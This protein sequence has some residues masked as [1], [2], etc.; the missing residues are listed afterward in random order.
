MGERLNCLLKQWDRVWSRILSN[1][2]CQ[3][4]N[5]RAFAR[6]SGNAAAQ[7]EHLEQR[8][9][10]S[11]TSALSNL[12]AE[13]TY[14]LDHHASPAASAPSGPTGY[15]PN[16]IR[17]AY[18]FSGT[19]NNGTGQTIAIVDAYDDPTIQNDLR[20]F[21]S[22]FGLANP[23]TMSVISQTGSATGLPQTD[24]TK[25]WE[26]EESL[27]VEWAHALAPAANI[28]L[29]EANSASYAD[30]LAAVSTAAHL[31]NVSVVSMSWGGSEFSGES[32][33][34]S[35][36]TTP[37]GHQGVTF[38][39]STGD[40]GAPGGFPAFSRNVV[41]VGG[42][43]LNVNSSG[44]YSSESGWSGSGGGIS[45]QE[46]QP[47][48]Q[49]GIVTQTTTKRAIP[50]V[51]FDADPNSGV[52]VYDSF[53]LGTTNPW[54][55]VGGTSFS[56]PAWGAIVSLA[57]QGRALHGLSSLDGASQA[58]PMLYQLDHT[59]P[60][61]FHDVTSGSNG[62]AAGTGYD[63]V[64]GL[65]TPVVNNLISGL[66]GTTTSSTSKLVFTQTPT[67]GTAGQTLGTL[68]VAIENLSGQVVTSDN[69]AVTLSI[70]SGPGGFTGASTVT[71]N[72]V[73]GIATFSNLV[74]NVSGAY[75][76]N[77]S[78]GT[79]TNGASG[80]VTINAAQA[81]KVAFQQ[82]PTAGV[83]GHALSTV[84]AAVEDQF[85]NVVATNN[86]NVTI[87]VASGGGSFASGS[88][89]T[90]SAVN[91][92]ATFNNLVLS[93]A[94]TYTLSATD[95]NLTRA[96][97][98][99]ISVTASLTAPQNF[100]VTALNSTTAQLSWSSVSGTQG[101][102]VFQVIGTQ[103]ILLGSLSSSATSAQVSG[104]LSGSTDSFKIEAYS[105]T[106]VADSRVV[107]VTMPTV[108]LTTPVLSISAI[109]STSVQLNWTVSEGTQGYR[110]Y[111]MNGTTKTLI[112]TV[113]ANMTSCTI[114]GLV[115]TTRYQ[116]QIEAFQGTTVLDS[117]W[118]AA[119]TTAN[120]THSTKAAVV[121]TTGSFGWLLESKRPF[122]C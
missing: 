69:S 8:T 40:N 30:L 74:L 84:T 41:A 96:T 76:L 52:P 59:S 112:G 68:K 67:S 6:N 80:T 2:A 114:V 45:T 43:T 103:S 18:G 28:V 94:G 9:L 17:S 10:L 108:R 47:S 97:S 71:V 46:S 22:Q 98:T 106:V 5:S 35:Y 72:A 107:S 122:Q 32:S 91:G 117:A 60:S 110:V 38:V 119:T 85:G 33:Y 86:S 57:D 78:D 75:T 82:T 104:L 79:I 11:A 26:V 29:V 120:N 73:N 55:Q 13:T 101:Y 12:Y 16:Q 27:D 109:T 64:T 83:I 1:P 118:V 19:S 36:F 4:R 105:G 56:A 90:V 62:F 87:S 3:R 37:A 58:L 99:G 70:G 115:H 24:S 61:S 21:D 65:G 111:W 77:D 49:T 116:F 50:D 20:A 88:S 89:T 95:G 54:E 34:D 25:G 53:S 92:I 121:V 66:T 51:S 23:P 31:S 48:Y 102:R 14:Q 63:L 100:T 7:I 44:N 39:A 93:A 42:T 15:S 113:P 81:A